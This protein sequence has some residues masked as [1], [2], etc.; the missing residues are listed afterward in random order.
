MSIKITDLTKK[1]GK[2][3]V[4]KSISLEFQEEKIYGL[5]GRNGVGKS[6]LLNIISNR[7]FK[8]SGEVLVDGEHAEENANAQQKIFLMSETNLYPESMKAAEIIKWTK[9]FY[10]DTDEKFAFELA[11]KFSLDTDKKFSALSTG[12]RTII[13]FIV[14]ISSKAKYTFLDEPVLGLDANHRELLYKTI[15]EE[16]AKNPRTIVISTHLIEEIATIIENVVILH[17]CKVVM[18]ESTENLLEK[19]YSVKGNSAEVEEFIKDKNCLGVEKV[20][21]VAVAYLL[22]KRPENI[23]KNIEVSG[24]NLQKI[25]VKLTGG[26][27][28]VWDWKMH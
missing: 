25:F 20:G 28:W 10:P 18:A 16:Y 2:N 3:T 19:G 22:E 27:S 4:L 17:E 13:K 1:Y 7:I 23:S 6:T 9:E 24:L 12:Q 15:I 5:L 26:E 8:T 21:T 14:A 11:K